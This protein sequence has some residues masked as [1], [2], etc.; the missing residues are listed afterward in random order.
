MRP[1]LRLSSRVANTA[2]LT[3]S[4]GDE[5][6]LRFGKGVA[7]IVEGALWGV[8]GNLRAVGSP[9]SD[10]RRCPRGMDMA[11]REEHWGTRSPSKIRHGL[12]AAIWVWLDGTPEVDRIAG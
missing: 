6:L 7:E 12:P 5:I 2:S 10:D 1:R 8:S 9:E 4:P 11:A 3:Q